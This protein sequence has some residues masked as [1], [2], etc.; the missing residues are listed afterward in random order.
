[1]AKLYIIPILS[2]IAIWLRFKLDNSAHLVSIIAFINCIA[3][4][5]LIINSCQT[6]CATKIKSIRC[7]ALP[8]ETK[9]AR[10]QSISAILIIVIILVILLGSL[11]S[12]KL[13]SPIINDVLSILALSISFI[14]NDVNFLIK[15][16]K[17]EKG[18]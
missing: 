18:E 2:I 8:Q 7:S 3:I 17:A 11:Y 12:I 1:M 5:Y 15:E 16:R 4:G 9:K 10:V 14:I 13:A 6:F